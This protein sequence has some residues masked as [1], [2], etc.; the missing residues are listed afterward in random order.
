MLKRARLL[1]LPDSVH[2][3]TFVMSLLINFDEIYTRCVTV[4]CVIDM[5]RVEDVRQSLSES[6]SDVG[7]RNQNSK[8]THWS[9]EKVFRFA[10]C[11]KN[12]IA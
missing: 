7:I 2:K 10:L 12:T 1:L 5:Y 3:Q 9:G 11:D 8:T 6:E 4:Y